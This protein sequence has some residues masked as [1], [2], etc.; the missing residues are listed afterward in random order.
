MRTQADYK[1]LVKR[2]E[3]IQNGPGNDS[4]GAYVADAL[5]DQM[6]SRST[7]L[8]RM[9]LQPCLEHMRREIELACPAAMTMTR[10][11]F[12]GGYGIMS[13]Q[14]HLGIAVANRNRAFVFTTTVPLDAVPKIPPDFAT[15]VSIWDVLNDQIE[16]TPEHAN[17]ADEYYEH[18]GKIAA[19]VTAKLGQDTVADIM[20]VTERLHRERYQNILLVAGICGVV[21]KKAG[22]GLIVMPMPAIMT[23][24]EPWK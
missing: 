23:D 22:G 1:S 14:N 13:E 8:T 18:L 19:I 3:R 12:Q 15:S 21:N 20:R 17:S 24:Q 10:K 6:L 2:L 11:G 7:E 16:E 4:L 9:V 5:R